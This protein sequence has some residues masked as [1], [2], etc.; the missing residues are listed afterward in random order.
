MNRDINKTSG[1]GL[2]EYALLLVF[3]A[4]VLLTAVTS[5]GQTLS[6]TFGNIMA[7]F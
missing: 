6:T 1:Q 5:I 2:P 3:V 7:M 4:I